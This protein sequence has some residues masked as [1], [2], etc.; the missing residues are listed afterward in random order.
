MRQI[1]CSD[2]HAHQLFEMPAKLNP[3]IKRPT[4]MI[5]RAFFLRL[6]VC[7][8]AAAGA[9]AQDTGSLALGQGQGALT[10]FENIEVNESRPNTANRPDRETRATMSEPIFTLIGTSRIGDRRSAILRHQNG[11]SIRVATGLESTARIAGYEE[12][13]V[14]DVGAGKLSVRYPSNVPCAEHKDKGVSCSST[15]NTAVLELVNAEA[16]ARAEPSS[17][18]GLSTELSFEEL[19]ASQAAARAGNPFEALRAARA[20]GLNPASL[21]EP[22][23]GQNSRFIPRRIAPE[24]VPPGMRVV[25]TPFGDRLVEQ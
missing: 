18:D 10:L 2:E 25:S 16:L 5:I 11:E 24:D 12:Y 14:F 6:M 1:D 23:G 15:P 17:V 13:S 19:A 9:V 20:A 3:Q 7:F 4:N 8:F 21:G 22:V